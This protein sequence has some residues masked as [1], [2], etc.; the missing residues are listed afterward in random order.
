MSSGDTAIR[1]GAAGL[2]PGPHKVRIESVDA[3]YMVCPGQVV[4]LTFSVPDRG[5]RATQGTS[6]LAWLSA[7]PHR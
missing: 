1:R 4:T 5:K 6:C 2:P 3:D 7:G